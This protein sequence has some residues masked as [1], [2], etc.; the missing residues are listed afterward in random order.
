VYVHGAAGA[1]L[2]A[3]HGSR[4]VVSSDLPL[5]IAAAIAAIPRPS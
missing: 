4:G 1:R 5:A 2:A 3:V